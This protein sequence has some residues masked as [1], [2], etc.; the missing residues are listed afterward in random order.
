MRHHFSSK[1]FSIFSALAGLP[2]DFSLSAVTAGVIA[3]IVSYG[4]PAAIIFQAAGQAGLSSAQLTSWIWAISIGSGVAGLVLSLLYRAPIIIAWST[5]GAA[6]LA[7]GWAAYPYP[8][9]IGAFVFAAL[10]IT[11]FGATGLFSALMERIAPAV[12]AAMLAGILLRF[13]MEVFTALKA[14]PQLVAPMLASYLALKRLW[15]RYAILGTLLAG[16]ATAAG[17]GMLD[18]STVDASLAIPV[19]TRPEFSLRALIGL[20]LPLFFVTMAGQNATGLGVLRTAGYKTPGGPL[21]A[22]TG[23]LSAV[24]APFGS[25]GI[26]L[27]AITA[28]ICTGAEAHAK[29]ERRYV[30]G[31]ACGLAYI[32]VGLFGATL[33]GLFTALPG[34]LVAAVSGLALF[35]ALSSGLS[36]AMA[37]EERREAALAA[38]LVTASGVGAFGVGSAFWGLLAGVLT[39]AILRLRR[40]PTLVPGRG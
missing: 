9:A 10:A 34:G 7:A 2:R 27:A 15:P 31:V 17:L 32:V 25:H 24:L 33:V 35:G 26:N 22:A 4:G 36:Q 12:V 8:E 37:D 5:P 11:F 21:V 14:T 29:P 23:A 6:L 38:F 19:L 30:A 3:V 39:D 1:T 13:G 40:P 16:L 20:G 18:V 28:A